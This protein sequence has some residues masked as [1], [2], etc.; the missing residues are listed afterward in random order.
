M[1][2]LTTLVI[3]NII[4]II[5]SIP[6]MTAGAALA[7]MHYILFQMIEDKEGHIVSSY[8]KQFKGNLRSATPIWLI[9]IF[10]AGIL[11]YEYS[12]FRNLGSAGRIVVIFVFAGAL[13]LAMMGVWLFPLTA[14]F[15]YTTAGCFRNAFILCIS[16]IFRTAAM[17]LIMSVIP[18]ILTH[19]LR[20]APLVLLVGITLPSYFCALIYHP[21]FA[22]MIKKGNR[23]PEEDSGSKEE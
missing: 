11:L 19:D 22:E 18:F 5:C 23:Q 16:K 8:M 13:F 15:V 10:C 21:V 9:M 2:D 3:I 12:A 4:T 6:I 7:S 20:L 1:R 17:V 14:K